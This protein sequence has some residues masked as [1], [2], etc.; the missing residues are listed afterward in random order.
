MEPANKPPV[1]PKRRGRTEIEFLPDADAIERNP[2]PRWLRM[3]LHVLLGL[4]VTFILWASLSQVETVVMA[5]GRLVNPRPNIVVQPLETA[6]IQTIEVRAGQVVKKG[7]LLATLDPTFTQADEAQLRNRLRSLDTQAEGLRAELSGKP[8]AAA[9]GG[10]DADQLL[11]AQLSTERQANYEAQKMRLEQ[12]IAR[13]KAGIET[14]QRDQQV[15]AQRLKS[16]SEIE[17]MQ[18]KLVAENFGAKMQL[19]EA[20][21]RRLEVER[22]MV[23]GRNK[24]VEMQRELNA[25]QAEQAAFSKNWRQRMM[26][27]LLTAT[28]DRDGINEQ[29]TKADRRH[30]LVQLTAPADAVVLEIAKLSPG[31]V[32]REAETMFTLVPLG[33]DLEAQVEID[34]LDIGHIKPGDPAHIKIDAFPFQRHGML[35]GKLRTISEDSFKREQVLPGQGTDAY[36]LGTLNMGSIKLRK[37]E[38]QQRLLPGMTLTAE[39]V[40]GKRSVMSYLLWPLTKALDESIREP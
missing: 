16:L 38:P 40:V 35:D 28:R 22:T 17:A 4:F 13:L 34:S 32:L 25:A 2:L 10:R 39:I 12:N 26:E 14:N 31:S 3:T 29:L 23:M 24:D 21:D 37:L 30:K 33:A 6:I 18:E 8:G 36:Y 1:S 20:R 7:Q 15:L 19:L 11:Q 5:H 27:D 9:A